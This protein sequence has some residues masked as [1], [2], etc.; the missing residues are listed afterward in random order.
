MEDVGDSDSRSAIT[1]KTIVKAL[2]QEM[3]L[4]QTVVKELV[5][6]LFEVITDCLVLNQ[7]LEL[8]NFGVF[9]VKRRRPRLGRNPKT[10]EEV[11]IGPRYSVTFKAG[12]NMEERLQRLIEERSPEN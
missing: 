8:R 7:R 5:E 9:E 12:K 3:Q 2:A 6:K 4:P 11:Q 10:N 1:K